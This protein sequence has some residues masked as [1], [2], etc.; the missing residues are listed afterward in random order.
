MKQSYSRI[1][2][3]FQ[4]LIVVTINESTASFWIHYIV[5]HEQK[6]LDLRLTE[7]VKGRG[8]KVLRFLF[9]G[10]WRDTDLFST[11]QG[12]KLKRT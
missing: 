3:K 4:Q 8:E 10:E 12:C 7:N 2:Q 9:E 5:T 1:K 11:Q 6:E